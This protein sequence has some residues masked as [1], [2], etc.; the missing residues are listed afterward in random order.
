MSCIHTRITLI[1]QCN[2][3]MD[4]LSC[5][6]SYFEVIIIAVMIISE[7]LDENWMTHIST[8]TN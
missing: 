1:S 2:Y 3:F 4:L 6:Q 7:S 8:L 5:M